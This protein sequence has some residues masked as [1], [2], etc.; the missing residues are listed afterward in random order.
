MTRL[1]NLETY[2]NGKK[3]PNLTLN[4]K[5]TRNFNPLLFI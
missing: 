2:K 5:S 4:E 3:D 1:K